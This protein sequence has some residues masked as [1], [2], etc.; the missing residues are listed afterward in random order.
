MP[1]LESQLIINADDRTAAA[2]ASVQ[3]RIEGL[4]SSM[5]ALD[6]GGGATAIGGR[7][8]TNAGAALASSGPALKEGDERSRKIPR[9]ST[10]TRRRLG[11]PAA[12]PGILVKDNYVHRLSEGH[13]RDVGGRRAG[14]RPG[15]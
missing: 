12:A 9:R 2:F 7:A 3:G 15:A 14:F 11:T 5:A 6:R 4:M 1:A 10:N 13:G 8:T